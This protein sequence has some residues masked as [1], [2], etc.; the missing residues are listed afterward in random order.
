MRQVLF[1]LCGLLLCSALTLADDKNA[2]SEERYLIVHADDA[3]MCHSVN[4]G[5]IEALEAGIVK[6]CSI[7]MPCPW[8]TE[9]A[10]Y[11]RQHP[12]YCYGIHFTLNAEWEHYRWGPVSPRNQVASM[13]DQDG[14]LWD[15]VPLVAANVKVDEVEKELRAQVERA[16]QLGIPISHLDTHMGALVSRSDLL[17]AYVRVGLDYDLPVLFLQRIGDDVARQYPALG[18]SARGL[19][20]VLQKERFPLLDNLVQFYGGETHEERRANYIKAIKALPP[21]V[22]QLI[23]HCGVLDEELRSVTSSAERRDGDRRIFTDP[24]I[25]RLIDDEGI[26]LIDWKEYRA[27]VNPQR[28]E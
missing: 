13:V 21:G 5:T 12:E 3:G 23:I 11:A 18:E 17:E 1:T 25:A 15:D 14:Y 27:M 6:S 19:L 7:M 20:G 28:A 24:Q 4:R 16:R 9:F 26:K 2:P 22:S 8:V 10:E